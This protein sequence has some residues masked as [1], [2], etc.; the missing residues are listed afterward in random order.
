VQQHADSI[1]N[2]HAVDDL[3]MNPYLENFTRTDPLR[4]LC[5]V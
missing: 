3:D 1:N 2:W 4:G 5:Q